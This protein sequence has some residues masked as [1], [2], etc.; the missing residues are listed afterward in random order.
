MRRPALIL[1][2]TLATAALYGADVAPAGADGT[3]QVF[4]LKDGRKLQGIY[5]RERGV[6]ILSGAVKSELR[7]KFDDIA[8]SEPVKG[9]AAA[10]AAAGDDGKAAGPAQSRD[11]AVQILADLERVLERDYKARHSNFNAQQKLRDELQ[12]ARNA[13]MGRSGDDFEAQE[14]ARRKRE[15]QAD[16]VEKAI[17]QLDAERS[18]LLKRWAFARAMRMSIQQ[19]SSLFES[20]TQ[21]PTPVWQEQR[22][23]DFGAIAESAR[24]KLAMLSERVKAHE[25]KRQD[26]EQERHRQGDFR[27]RALVD[28]EVKSQR[29][30]L[31][32]VYYSY[33][34]N[35]FVNATMTQVPLGNLEVPDD[36]IA[37]VNDYVSFHRKVVDYCKRNNK[38]I[39]VRVVR[40]FVG[41]SKIYYP[42]KKLAPPMDFGEVIRD[43]RE[44]AELA[45]TEEVMG[46]DP[47]TERN[48]EFEKMRMKL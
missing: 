17:D 8:K 25:A 31:I 19:H 39:D 22:T 33:Y 6:I 14:A 34:S 5:D 11:Y 10:V 1:V 47:S 48:S 42:V 15:A 44:Y 32:N 38:N 45:P 7:V 29:H 28:N 36:D 4:T 9:G 3:M 18:L 37:I 12:R 35:L 30:D 41:V 2:A 46:F 40:I 43:Y 27:N 24:G 21:A 20:L 16:K 26:D 13:D 23:T